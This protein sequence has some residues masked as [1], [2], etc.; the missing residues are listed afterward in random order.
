MPNCKDRTH[1]I[2]SFGLDL[3]HYNPCLNQRNMLHHR[4][5][6][7]SQLSGNY[8]ELGLVRGWGWVWGWEL[9]RE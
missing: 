6:P 9:V 8:L 2:C 7:V 4:K 1:K 3:L 5:H